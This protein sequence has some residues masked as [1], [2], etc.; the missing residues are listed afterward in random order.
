MSTHGCFAT[1]FSPYPIVA[2]SWRIP[3][4]R[5]HH[6][7]LLLPRGCLLP[8]DGRRRPGVVRRLPGRR[9]CLFNLCCFCASLLKAKLPN[10]C[11]YSDIVA[12]ADSYVFMLMYFEPLRPLSCNIKLVLFYF[13]SRVVLWYLT[14]SPWSWSYTFSCIISV[15]LNW[16]HHSCQV[17]RPPET[18][19]TGHGGMTW[20]ERPVLWVIRRG[21]MK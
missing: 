11:L 17:I 9:P 18:P 7:G 15:W 8:R 19:P 20:Q 5:R 2:T 12:S 13:V 14:M 6:W 1:S 4:A 3:R 21:T 16:G 10:L